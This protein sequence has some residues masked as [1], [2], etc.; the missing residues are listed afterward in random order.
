MTRQRILLV[1]DESDIL[2]LVS[3][4]LQRHGYEVLTACDGQ[5][6][7]EKARKDNPDLFCKKEAGSEI[8]HPQ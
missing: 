4:R 5:E 7:L 3:T 8:E 1:D 2:T 6:A